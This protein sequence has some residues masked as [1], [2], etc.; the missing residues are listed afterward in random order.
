MSNKILLL[1]ANGQLGKE[2]SFN[3]QKFN[4][5]PLSKEECDITD[6]NKLI[7]NLLSEKP[8][9]VIN[10]SAYTKVDGAEENAKLANEI[11]GYSLIQLARACKELDALL[12]HYSTDYVF[13]GLNS[14]PYTENDETNPIN[15][16]GHSKLLGEKSILDNCE[17]CY[18]F[19]TSWVYGVYGNNFPKT[20]I[21]LFQK[22]D[23]VSVV[24]DQEGIP[25]STVF[26]SKITEFFIEDYL[27]SKPNT[28]GIYNLVP[29]SSCTWHDVASYILNYM[30]EAGLPTKTKQVL[31][32]SSNKFK[33]AAK[34]PMYSVLDNKKIN[35]LYSKYINNWDIYLK[36]F[37][38]EELKNG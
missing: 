26:L 35:K 13:N 8:K 2:I 24:D 1:G 21:K 36:H 22:N 28:Y 5:I 23:D 37:L 19:R 17:K 11:N 6:S 3:F 4:I 34:R 31:Q 20:M 29:N 14:S 27:N 9:I 30:Q 18:I 7:D 25:T 33:T 15:V 10:C 38:D 16:Y 12:V 32:C